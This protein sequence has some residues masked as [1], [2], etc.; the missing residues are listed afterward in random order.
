MSN[1]ARLEAVEDLLQE[2][3][4]LPAVEDRGPLRRAAGLTQQQVALAVGVGR[5][6]VARWETGTAEPRG[7]RRKAYSHLLKSLTRRSAARTN[8]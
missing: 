1:Q 6:Q 4:W 7:I 3:V 5:V 8:P 2:A